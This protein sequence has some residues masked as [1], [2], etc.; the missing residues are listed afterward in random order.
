MRESMASPKLEL[1]PGYLN[2]NVE[3]RENAGF[4]R[5][6]VALSAARCGEVTGE[7]TGET[8]VDSARWIWRDVA[9]HI[10]GVPNRNSRP[11]YLPGESDREGRGPAR[12]DCVAGARKSLAQPPIFRHKVLPGFTG[13]AQIIGCRGETAELHQTEQRMND[14][15]EFLRRWSP[16]LGLKILITTMLQITRRQL[17]RLIDS[18]QLIR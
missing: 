12:D 8:R 11:T 2:L 9:M 6:Y 5:F 18:G 3:A 4:S 13:L 17:A 16:L 7:V 10:E 15:L 14:G 1:W